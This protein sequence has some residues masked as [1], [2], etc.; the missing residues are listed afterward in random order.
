[1]LT[2]SAIA[3]AVFCLDLLEQLAACRLHARRLPRAIKEPK[4]GRKWP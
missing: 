1:M 3:S 2:C 4:G